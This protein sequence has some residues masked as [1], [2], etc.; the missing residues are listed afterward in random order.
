[1]NL[2]KFDELLGFHDWFYAFSDDGRVWRKGEEE[3]RIIEEVVK[4]D[5][6]CKQLLELYSRYIFADNSF[7]KD[8]LTQEQF[9]D[10]RRKFMEANK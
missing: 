3:T 6:K 10:L 7:T 2:K 1:M 9:L 4:K 8:P 5:P